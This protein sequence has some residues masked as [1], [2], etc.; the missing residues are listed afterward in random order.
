MAE[1]FEKDIYFFLFEICIFIF[2]LFFD[3]F[4]VVLICYIFLLEG[5]LSL[6]FFNLFIYYYKTF[7]SDFLFFTFNFK[8]KTFLYPI[9]RNKVNDFLSKSGQVQ[10][11]IFLFYFSNSIG[12]LYKFYRYILLYKLVHMLFFFKSHIFNNTQMNKIFNNDSSQIFIYF[13]C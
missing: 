11:R 12:V 9:D 7:W 10:R 1:H 8:K 13:T 6:N 5:L 3:P 2:V 4:S